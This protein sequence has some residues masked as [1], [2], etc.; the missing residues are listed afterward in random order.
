MKGTEVLIMW[1]IIEF[2]A[3]L[4]WN[5]LQL[6][7]IAK[8]LKVLTLLQAGYLSCCFFKIRASV[9]LYLVFGRYVLRLLQV[10]VLS[11]Y[12]ACPYGT[13]GALGYCDCCTWRPDPNPCV[14]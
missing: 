14:L 1:I 3:E 12:P 5:Y 7:V 9:F 6:D 8:V 4:K 11:T 13:L 10:L 2:K